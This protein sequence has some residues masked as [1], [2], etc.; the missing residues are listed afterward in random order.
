MKLKK[1]GLRIIKTAIAV[2]IALILSH[3]RSENSLPFYAAIAAVICM[4]P[5]VD[6]TIDVG[7]NR[8]IGTLIGGLAGLVYL[9]LFKGLITHHF[10]NYLII[11][12]SI[13]FL[14]W[15]LDFFKKPNAISIMAIVFLSI[16]INH[17]IEPEYPIA[18]AMNRT[19]D[20]LMGVV[21][22][23]LVNRIHFDYLRKNPE[24]KGA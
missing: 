11:S 14:I 2:F 13:I 5:N 22:A 19:I 24:E 16:T 4:K 20:T 21:V 17:G 9:I 7:I 18:F 6:G 8:V 10:I 1:P 12:I 15:L 23:I 3:L